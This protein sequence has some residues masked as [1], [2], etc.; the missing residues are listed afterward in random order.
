M[1][2]LDDRL[3]EVISLSKQ[4]KPIADFEFSELHALAVECSELR[5]AR[6]ELLERIGLEQHK[7]ITCGVAASHPDPALSATYQPEWQS[8]QAE[9]VR[10]LRASR[11]ALRKLVE[12]IVCSDRLRHHPWACPVAWA[13]PGACTCGWKALQ[14]RINEAL[15]DKPCK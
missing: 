11:D 14:Q 7:V 2:L 4:R 5:D 12:D 9:E 13:T 15:E 10:K 6:A 8:P 1:K 3:A